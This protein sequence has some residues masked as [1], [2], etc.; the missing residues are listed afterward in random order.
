VG[1][2]EDARLQ[3]RLATAHAL[4]LS[5]DA[6]V[7]SRIRAVD[8]LSRLASQEAHT[9]LMQL[10]SGGEA[11]DIQA[12]AVAAL[13]RQGRDGTGNEL[14]S[15]WPAL[16]PGVRS[17]V[18]DLLLA[19]RH[20]HD[21]L[22]GALENNQ[23]A[24]SELN[25]DLE[26]RRTLMRWSS[27][28]I[29]E[30]AARLFGDEEYS[31]RKEIVDE[32]LA[33]L[34]RQGDPGLGQAVF[35]K[36]CASCH[37]SGQL[38]NQVGPDLTGQGHRSVEDLLTHILD[39][40]MAIHPNYITCAVVTEAGEIVS[41]ILRAEDQESITLLMSEAKQRTIPRQ[42][43]AEQRTLKTSLMPEGLEKELTPEELRAVIAFVQLSR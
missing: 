18:I 28:E 2:A 42:E 24:F 21:A 6:D 32:W 13:R 27:P 31:N 30:R 5:K 20:Y 4:A 19:R 39:P 17:A 33:K 23:I 37:R 22:V 3:R 9:T 10:L 36:R 41:G 29:G 12:A 26:Q 11:T 35:Q 8:V 7:S 16:S 25:L 1:T 14:V 15:L 34:P 40:N 43:I 38:G